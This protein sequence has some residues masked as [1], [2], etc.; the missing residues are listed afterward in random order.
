MLGRLKNIA[1]EWLDTL[2]VAISVAMA[3]RA[4][5]YEPFNIPTGSMQPTLYGNHYQECKEPG[6]WQKS[7]LKWL[8]WIATGRDYKELTAPFNAKVIISDRDDGRIDLT[9]L[10]YGGRTETICLPTD[11]KDKLDLGPS[12]KNHVFYP[13]AGARRSAVVCVADAKGQLRELIVP[14][15]HCV[16]SGYDTTGDFVFVNRWKWHFRLPSRGDVMIFSTTGINGLAQG[17]HYIKRVT[18]LPNET[19]DIKDS[20]IFINGEKMPD[21]KPMVGARGEKTPLP[22]R[23]DMKGPVRTGEYEYFTCGDNSDNS[24]DSRYW[25]TVPE[26]NV[27]G[28]AACVF[29]PVINR[30]WGSIK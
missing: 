7:P 9:L 5:F 28:C 2:V 8:N 27:T 24:Y 29:W 3:F 25:G 30:R 12:A 20:S 18:G 13:L 1:K 23:A 11:C 19:V 26:K 21:L 4:Y 16:F 15:G 14:K 6:L 17:T 10:D 22:C